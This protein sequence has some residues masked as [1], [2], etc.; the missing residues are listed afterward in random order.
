MVYASAV[1]SP[2]FSLFRTYPDIKSSFG[3]FKKLSP[4]EAK[5]DKELRAHGIRVLRTVETV[6]DC[7]YDVPRTVRVL[8][9]LGRKH[10][11]FSAKPD[12]IDV[13]DCKDS[14]VHLVQNDT[15]STERITDAL[16]AHIQH[17]L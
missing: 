8:H 9:N 17:I 15:Q 5:F 14:S 2:I 12:Y 7:R 13:S 16:S 10:V 4:E 3:P 11:T 6:L 1:V